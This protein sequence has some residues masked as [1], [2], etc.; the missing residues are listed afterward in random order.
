MP[1][2][3]RPHRNNIFLLCILG[4]FLDTRIYAT[5][6]SN[7]APNWR[8]IQHRLVHMD[9]VE[10]LFEHGAFPPVF[11]SSGGDA[12]KESWD[13]QYNMAEEVLRAVRSEMEAIDV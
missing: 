2:V 7:G 4:S 10:A 3:P 11:D 8:S 5:P 1:F 13:L 9:D 12:I 6:V